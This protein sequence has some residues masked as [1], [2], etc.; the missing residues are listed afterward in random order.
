MTNH[1]TSKGFIAFSAVCE[2]ISMKNG[3]WEYEISRRF[4]DLFSNR[5]WMHSEQ[6]LFE[7]RTSLPQEIVVTQLYEVL[8]LQNQPN[9]GKYIWF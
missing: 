8:D 3:T 1:L 5:S 7:K 2:A 4:G 9:S 6:S